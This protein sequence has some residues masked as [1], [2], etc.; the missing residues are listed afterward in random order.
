MRCTRATGL[1]AG[2]GGTLA[3]SVLPVGAVPVG[4]VSE[5]VASRPE[6]GGTGSAGTST[7]SLGFVDEEMTE[8]AGKP[9]RQARSAARA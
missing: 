7:G 5:V 8:Q 9:I 3:A 4:E 2:N 1:N 6:S